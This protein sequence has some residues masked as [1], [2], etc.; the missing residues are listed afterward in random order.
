M[1]RPRCTLEKHER[2]LER[3]RILGSVA[4]FVITIFLFVV[5]PMFVNP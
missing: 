4:T 3:L 1:P 5:A 2:Q